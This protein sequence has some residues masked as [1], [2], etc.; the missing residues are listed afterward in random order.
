MDKKHQHTQ[1]PQTAAG[2]LDTS[3]PFNLF[4]LDCI[5]RK[6]MEIL[7]SDSR[8]VYFNGSDNFRT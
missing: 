3:K 4:C 2:I 1:T 5:A 7:T 6:S 8:Q